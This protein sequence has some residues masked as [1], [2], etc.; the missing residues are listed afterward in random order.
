L[1]G[2]LERFF[3]VLIEHYNGNFPVWL[4][5]VQVI[6]IPIADRHNEYAENLSKMFR[7]EGLRAS[8]DHRREKVGYKIRDAEVH[9]IP[10]MC[11]VGD[12]EVSDV[13]VSPRVHG[14]GDKGKVDVN[15]FLEKVKELVKNKSASINL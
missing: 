5:P 11:I 13:A 12:R 3:G 7:Q 2:S 14:A 6:F 9:K 8:V 15:E 4:A 10:L 1:L